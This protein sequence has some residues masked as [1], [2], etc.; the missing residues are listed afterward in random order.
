M[1]AQAMR[2]PSDVWQKRFS[3]GIGKRP[4]YLEPRS[5]MSPF[6]DLAMLDPPP[7]VR[8]PTICSSSF[9]PVTLVVLRCWADAQGAMTIRRRGRRTGCGCADSVSYEIS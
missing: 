6:I 1:L 8:V 5:V 9:T 7:T 2:T 3:W 4:G